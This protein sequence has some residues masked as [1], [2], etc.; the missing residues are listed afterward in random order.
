MKSPAS[1]GLFVVCRLV[2][3]PVAQ[4]HV[5]SPRLVPTPN[6]NNRRLPHK[7]YAC[8]ASWTAPMAGTDSKGGTLIN[9]MSQFNVV[10]S[11]DDW[12]YGQTAAVPVLEC[13]LH[14]PARVRSGSETS[15]RGPQAK[16]AVPASADYVALPPGK[17]LR[18]TVNLAQVY[19]LSAPGYYEVA[20]DGLLVDVASGTPSAA[21]Q[22]PPSLDCTPAAVEITARRWR[23]AP[24]AM[25]I[26]QM[27]GRS[28]TICDV[29]S[30]KTKGTI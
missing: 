28:T 16:R 26:R 1:A 9:E 15:Y 11:T 29:Y 23:S 12:A 5:F 18:A 21:T 14:L 4:R 27:P 6:E 3:C 30:I 10:A 20:C 22:T 7:I 13:R 2:G 19:D 17:R 8:R 25:G 24:P